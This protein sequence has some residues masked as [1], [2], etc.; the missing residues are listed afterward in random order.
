MAI[1]DAPDGTLWVQQVDVVVGLPE[2]PSKPSV[3]GVERDEIDSGSQAVTAGAE[4]TYNGFAS[5]TPTTRR[6][7]IAIDY[8]IGVTAGDLF[9]ADVMLSREATRA[10]AL[11]SGKNTLGLFHIHKHSDAPYVN[12]RM[13]IFP[14]GI[15]I[16]AGDTL[17]GN[18]YAHNVGASDG[19][20]HLSISVYHVPA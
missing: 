9:E 12:D 13:D 8:W 3:T 6:R 5:W 19:E 11:T 18:G 7:I 1:A 17:Y 16:E 15:T 14:E 10:L 4:L 2:P 20:C